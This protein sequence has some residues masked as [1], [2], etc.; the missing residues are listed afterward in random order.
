M[1]KRTIWYYTIVER[2]ILFTKKAC[3]EE[4]K[5]RNINEQ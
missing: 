4:E 3:G 5:R 1:K 2:K